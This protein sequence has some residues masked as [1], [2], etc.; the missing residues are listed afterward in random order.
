VDLEWG[1]PLHHPLWS[2]A[3]LV[4]LAA[5]CACLSA[6]TGAP[7]DA[8]GTALLP[9]HAGTTTERLLSAGGGEPRTGYIGAGLQGL[10]PSS[11]GLS[12]GLG[13]D[14]NYTANI[15]ERFSVELSLG[16][17]GYDADGVGA[18]A[19]LKAVTLGAVAQVGMPFGASRW[20]AGGGLV[21]WMNDLSGAAV[22]ADDS[23]AFTVAAGA[24]LPIAANGNLCIE[25]RYMLGDADLSVGAPLDLDAFAVRA[26]Y[27]FKY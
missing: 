13:I 15:A 22:D 21:Y 19:E 18:G 16:R 14:V 20:Y 3:P 9:T 8:R 27:V 6:E 12:G 26:N 7:V 10:F 4:V 24:D 1:N 2:A 23:L 11:D 17:A 25:L 5:G